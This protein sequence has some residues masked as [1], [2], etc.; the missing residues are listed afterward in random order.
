MGVRVV[1]FILLVRSSTILGAKWVYAGCYKNE[2]GSNRINGGSQ[3]K[4]TFANCQQQAISAGK[5]LFALEYPKCCTDP[6]TTE[7]LVLD[8][9]PKQAQTA[10]ADC[11][12]ESQGG[13]RL[14]N[15]NR[16]AVY[17][18]PP[19]TCNSYTCATSGWVQKTG[20]ALTVLP[21]DKTQW[22]VTC[23]QATIKANGGSSATLAGTTTQTPWDSSVSSNS[24]NSLAS[25]YSGSLNTGSSASDV[26][27]SAAGFGSTASGSSGFFMQLWQWTLF[28]ALICFGV[29]G[30]ICAIVLKGGKGSRSSKK[31]KKGAEKSE[32]ENGAK[33]QPS[34]SQYSN[35]GQQPT[36]P[37]LRNDAEVLPLTNPSTPMV[38]AQPYTGADY[39]VTPV[40]QGYAPTSYTGSAQSYAGSMAPSTSSY[41]Y[42]AAAFPGMQP[43][44]A[45]AIPTAATAAY[46]TTTYPSQDYAASTAAYGMAPSYPGSYPGA[47]GGYGAGMVGAGMS[48]GYGAPSPTAY[49]GAGGYQR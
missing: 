31:S 3:N 25:S 40:A 15:N 6:M 29:G 45:T 24:G 23:C 1:G 11:E 39:T 10:D 49:A 34:Y 42:A 41:D 12:D 21:A 43:T 48:P 30:I 19:A 14:G 20:V 33:Q 17:N 37:L 28:G 7:C 44:A 32:R 46:P 13:A 9:L 8:A 4:V 26:F 36:A 18:P 2:Q 47:G 16:L 27:Q 35:P 38:Y 22:E 5:K